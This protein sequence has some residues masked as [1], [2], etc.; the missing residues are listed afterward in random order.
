MFWRLKLKE[1]DYKIIYKAGKSN[2]NAD[3]LSDARNP[4]WND[5]RMHNVQS[6]EKKDN[7]KEDKDGITKEYTEE[8]KQ[9]ILYEYHDASAGGHQ[10]IS[11]IKK[12]RLL[13]GVASRRMSKTILV[14]ANS[15]RKIN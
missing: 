13:T 12:I 9:Q 15:V 4:I 7:N 3:A 10:E 11:R 14:N 2:T 5:K 1:Y 6:K 8:E